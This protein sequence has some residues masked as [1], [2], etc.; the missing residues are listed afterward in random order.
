MINMDEIEFKR[1]AEKLYNERSDNLNAVDTAGQWGDKEF[2]PQICE[3]ILKKIEIKKNDIVLEVGCGSGVLGSYLKNKCSD[4]YGIDISFKMLQKFQGEY[5]QERWLNLTQAVT[6]ALPFP[7]N[8]FSKILINGVT[9]YLHGKKLLENTLS[10]LERVSKKNSI[11]FIGENVTPDGICWEYSWFQ[12]KSSISQFFAK[13]YIKLRL[14][15][16]ELNPKLAGKWKFHYKSVSYEF[17]R[18]F[19]GVR[20]KTYLSESA[21]RT[22]KKRVYGEK[23]KGN[24]RVDF[25]IRFD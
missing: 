19:F 13:R 12:S 23:H 22:I 25:I 24:R 4:Y 17:I 8:T 1:W 16:A 9:M 18:K 21:A 10:E 7:N 20:A 15:L 11:I 3:E 14:W 5:N 2:V 6:D